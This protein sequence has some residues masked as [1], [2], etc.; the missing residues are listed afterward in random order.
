[1]SK[2]IILSILFLVLL[3]SGKVFSQENREAV[4]NGYKSMYEYLYF[5]SL[6]KLSNYQLSDFKNS[7]TFYL[8]FKIDTTATVIDL[9]IIE[10][11]GAEL[12]DFIKIYIEK[13]VKATNGRWLPQII[14]SKKVISD[15]MMYQVGLVK[16]D[17]SLQDRERDN[18]PVIEYFFLG[19]QKKI[20]RIEKIAF[21]QKKRLIPLSY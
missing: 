6:N 9:D 14:D 15:E 2:K 13:L 11:P 4:I 21:S 1:M 3:K 17:Q 8:T 20:D 10:I 7:Y 19:S 12:P 5:D 16:K 18:A